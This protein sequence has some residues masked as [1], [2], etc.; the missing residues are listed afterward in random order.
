MLR[1]FFSND[2]RLSISLFFLVL[3]F[4]V[5]SMPKTI[6][7]EDDGIFII[8][9]YFG[10]VAHP[11]GYPLYTSIAHLF[12]QIPIGTVAARVHFVSALFGA[13]SCVFIY[14]LSRSFQVKQV[15]AYLLSLIFATSATFWSQSIISEVYSL[16]IFLTAGSIYFAKLIANYSEVDDYKLKLKNLALLCLFA[17]LGL[18]NHWPLY[19]LALPAIFVLLLKDVGFLV[20]HF[21][22]A[23]ISLIVLTI[24]YS[25]LYYTNQNNDQI[26]IFGPF[27]QFDDFIGFVARSH[28]K[29]T[30][31]D[32]S[33]TLFDKL[34]F[35]KLLVFE[36]A[37]NLHILLIPALFGILHLKNKKQYFTIISCLLLVLTSLLIIIMLNKNYDY[38][39]SLVYKVYFIPSFLGILIFANAAFVEK[40]E[41]MKKIGSRVPLNLVLLLILTTNLV[42]NK[43]SFR[44]EYRFGEDYANAVFKQIPESSILF[45]DGDINLGVLGYYKLI[46]QKRPDITLYSSDS[47]ILNNRL[48]SKSTEFRE[49]HSILSQFIEKTER[50]VIFAGNKISPVPQ[51]Y[52]WLFGIP[53]ERGATKEATSESFGDDDYEFLDLLLKYAVLSDPWTEFFIQRLITRAVRHL[54]LVSI[55]SDDLKQKKRALQYLNSIPASFQIR[56]MRVRIAHEIEG[57]KNTTA[58]REELL[59]LVSQ[60]NYEQPKA[61]R[62]TVLN[63][64]AE[65]YLLTQNEQLAINTINLSCKLWNHPQNKACQVIVK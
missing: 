54:T 55:K 33:A 42:L 46:E 2:S 63:L 49:R 30:D 51:E 45:A 36:I 31:S 40:S 52:H 10:S 34:A 41:F 26:S 4:Y 62:A 58:I 35:I 32:P 19:V 65:N 28:Y 5:F 21:Y 47:Y 24:F 53:L 48:Y 23:I 15:P 29:I 50:N 12:S 7:L 16:N 25:Y 44:D 37:K 9:S 3:A 17:G 60:F 39:N 56:L 18:S 14:W 59:S 13:L 22:Y 64:L 8:T 61:S 1:E 6:A 27:E 11:P 20:R 57:E 38:L 43:D